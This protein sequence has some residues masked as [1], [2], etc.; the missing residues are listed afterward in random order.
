MLYQISRYFN[1]LIVAFNI[2]HIQIK[3]ILIYKKIKYEKQKHK[4]DLII[5]I[6]IFFYPLV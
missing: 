3:E 4:N 6:L 1:K 2:I 5:Y